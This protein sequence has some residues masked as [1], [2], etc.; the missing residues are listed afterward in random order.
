MS[1]NKPQPTKEQL[2]NEKAIGKAFLKRISYGTGSYPT[3][4]NG[5][6]VSASD[7]KADYAKF[8]SPQDTTQ[9]DLWITEVLYGYQLIG[10][11]AASR[12][13][14]KFY[15]Q[16]FRKNPIQVKGVSRDETE[17]NA[18]AKFIREQQVNATIDHNN[19]FL[20]EIPGAGIRAIG[21]IPSFQAG[22]DAQNQGIPVAPEFSFEFVV[23][24]DL[25]D[26]V[27]SN[28]DYGNA[29]FS[30]FQKNN[31]REIV[32]DP[33]L[34]AIYSKDKGSI[35]PFNPSKRPLASSTNPTE[36]IN[37]GTNGARGS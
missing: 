24:R 30:S 23:F 36:G 13:Y 34:P 28:F 31:G 15:P 27:D 21:A 6:N 20:L 14:N 8:T 37:N 7:N 12:F 11:N 29:S 9:F 33:T 18:L 22:I 25:T 17:Y 10:S 1:E 3:G 5:F 4:S 32:D 2:I 35:K 19:L 26:I 16:Y